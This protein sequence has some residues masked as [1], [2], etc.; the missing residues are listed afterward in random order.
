MLSGKQLQKLGKRLRAEAG[1]EDLAVLNAYRRWFDPALLE[2]ALQINHAFGRAETP[3][4]L[5]GRAK[6][7]KSVIRK[8]VRSPNMDLGRMTDIVGLRIVVD[9]LDAQRRVERDLPHV[10]ELERWAD[11]RGEEHLY[12]ALHA[13]GR[14]DGRRFEVQVRT[15]AQQVWADESESFGEQAKEGR[16]SPVQGAYLRELSRAFFAIEQG[17]APPPLET[18]IAHARRPID[19]RLNSMRETFA[20]VAAPMPEGQDHTMLVVHDEQLNELTRRTDYCLEDREEALAEYE[21]LMSQLEQTRF[22]VLLLNARS[23]ESLKVT[24]PRFFSGM[25]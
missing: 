17:Q 23:W 3:Y 5:S 18:S 24:H 10:L 21:R 22:S 11:Y 6:R 20:Q 9:D 14:I 15:L 7:S 25:G 1:K 4:L 2:A 16:T 13:H 12:R 19:L 8:L